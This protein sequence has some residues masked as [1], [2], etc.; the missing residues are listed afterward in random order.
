MEPVLTK[1]FM[2]KKGSSSSPTLTTL[3]PKEPPHLSSLRSTTTSTSRPKYTT[4]SSNSNHSSPSSTTATTDPTT[5]TT[6]TTSYPSTTRSASSSTSKPM[7]PTT[8]NVFDRLYNSATRRNK[9][10]VTTTKAINYCSTTGGNSR[11]TSTSHSASATTTIKNNSSSNRKT[12]RPPSLRLLPSTTLPASSSKGGVVASVRKPSSCATV[13]S[14]L[15]ISTSRKCNTVQTRTA[16]TTTNSTPISTK[17]KS[18]TSSKL[19][20]DPLYPSRNEKPLDISTQMKEEEHDD[21]EEQKACYQGS[22]ACQLPIYQFPPLSTAQHTMKHSSS[23]NLQTLLNDAEVDYQA[24]WEKEQEELNLFVLLEQQGLWKTR[25]LPVVQ[26]QRIFRGYIVRLTVQMAV[27]KASLMYSSVVLLQTFYRIIIRQQL[28]HRQQHKQRWASVSIQSIIRQYLQQIYFSKQRISCSTIQRM[29]RRSHCCRFCQRR[30]MLSWYE[31]GDHTNNFSD[32]VTIPTGTLEK[33][34]NMQELE[35]KKDPVLHILQP[36]LLLQSHIRGRI[37]RTFLHRWIGAIVRIQR[38]LRRHFLRCSTRYKTDGSCNQ[39]TT[40]NDN[41]DPIIVSRVR[42]QSRIRQQQHNCVVTM[43]AIE[44]RGKAITAIQGMFRRILIKKRLPI[45]TKTSPRNCICP[46]TVSTARVSSAIVRIQCFHRQCS[47]SWFYRE[48]RLVVIPS[49]IRI[50]RLVIRQGFKKR[51]RKRLVETRILLTSTITESSSIKIQ[52]WYRCLHYWYHRVGTLKRVIQL[53]NRLRMHSANTVYGKMR[54]EICKLQHKAREYLVHRRREHVQIV[55]CIMIQC[56]CRHVFCKTNL[57]HTLGSICVIQRFFRCIWIHRTFL[58]FIHAVVMM[59]KVIRRFL[60]YRRRLRS[61][62]LQHSSSLIVRQ[63]RQWLLQRNKKMQEVASTAAALRSAIIVQSH[64]RKKIC[65]MQLSKSRRAFHWMI[66]YARGYLAKQSLEKT[67]SAVTEIQHFFLRYRKKY[68]LT[69]RRNAATNIQELFRL[70]KKRCYILS[71]TLFFRAIQVQSIYRCYFARKRFSS[72]IQISDAIVGDFRRKRAMDR[73]HR[74]RRA[75]LRVQHWWRRKLKIMFSVR[76]TLQ[77]ATVLSR[78]IIRAEATVNLLLSSKPNASRS[79]DVQ[80]LVEVVSHSVF[81]LKSIR[82]RKK[83][84]AAQVKSEFMKKCHIDINENHVL[85]ISRSIPLQASTNVVPTRMEMN[86]SILRESVPGI[87]VCKT[88]PSVCSELGH[89]G[90]PSG[91]EKRK[92]MIICKDKKKLL[93]PWVSACT[94]KTRNSYI[95]S[96]NSER[97]EKLK[98]IPLMSIQKLKGE[99]SNCQIKTLVHQLQN[100]VQSGREQVKDRNGAV[101]CVNSG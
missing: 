12:T 95:V 68:F 44:S 24:W 29:V 59:Q 39:D 84:V 45:C 81:R 5:M 92:K 52:S 13:T 67:V 14:P 46:M 78:A 33:Q 85:Q 75:A 4:T 30:N 38:F 86:D 9:S 25:T 90:H 98:T 70:Y 66:T 20:L 48:Q 72:A 96:T 71:L 32:S 57:N 87:N 93:V 58:R 65:T 76:K 23:T 99:G 22:A 97:L 61:K 40:N 35:E 43:V 47:S 21:E 62:V 2:K 19:Q 17:A 1:S 80:A 100:L 54:S 89:L 15:A 88:M 82:H 77:E 79:L 26:L 31:N 37:A 49:V 51:M 83:I 6:M 27:Q 42:N 3:P 11:R 91:P 69:Q 64:M 16:T 10:T 50:Q 28:Q 55:S 34:Q 36:T 7:K 53:Q 56:F 60:K 74:M 41:W 94:S 101:R 63:S 73:Y 8:S 18:Q